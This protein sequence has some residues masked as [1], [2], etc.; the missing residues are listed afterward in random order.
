M[1][2]RLLDTTARELATYGRVEVLASIRAAR[3]GCSPRRSSRL[4][5][6]RSMTSATPR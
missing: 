4:Q 5:W 3:V 6:P 1:I 2:K